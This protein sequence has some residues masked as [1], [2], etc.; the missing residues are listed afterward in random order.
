MGLSDHSIDNRV[1]FAAICSGA[2]IV[3]KHIGLNNQKKGLDLKFS[4]KGKEIKKFRNTIDLAYSLLG[5]KSF[6][7]NKSE[8]KNKIYRRSIFTIKKISKGDKF[9]TN[10]IKR[11]RPGFGLP[12]VYYQKILGKKSPINIDYAEPLSFKLLK[13]LK[14]K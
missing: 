6:F 11:I 8:N 4:L 12:S 2:E 7:R 3:E 1:A 10:N 9:N 14:I 5:K 13:K